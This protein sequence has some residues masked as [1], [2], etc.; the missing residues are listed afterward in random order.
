MIAVLAVAM[1]VAAGLQRRPWGLAVALALQVAMIACGLLVPALGVMGIV[2]ALV[3]AI[4]L[5]LRHDVARRLT[6]SCNPRTCT[7]GA[8]EVA[9]REPWLL[10]LASFSVAPPSSSGRR[11]RGAARRGGSPCSSPGSCSST[12]GVGAGA[13]GSAAAGAPAPAPVVLARGELITHEHTT[14]GSVQVLGLPD[15]SRVL[16]LQDLDTSDGPA[17]EGVDHRRR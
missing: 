14:T 12:A 5:C 17:A 4:L 6:R 13:D 11:R 16:R 9:L 15:G 1:I 2:F 8:G 7:G 10:C 3:W